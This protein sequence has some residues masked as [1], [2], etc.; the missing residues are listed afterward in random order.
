MSEMIEQLN[1]EPINIRCDTHSE[2]FIPVR[3]T[4]YCHG[5]QSISMTSKYLSIHVRVSRHQK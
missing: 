3:V 1:L 2:D 4:R 5:Q